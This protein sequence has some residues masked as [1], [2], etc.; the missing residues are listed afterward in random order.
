MAEHILKHFKMYYY[1]LL[2]SDYCHHL[3]CYLYNVSAD[4][5]YGLLQVFLDGLGN[6]LGLGNLFFGL[7]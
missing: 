1:Y 4:M 5:P 7:E 3:H 6:L 2:Y